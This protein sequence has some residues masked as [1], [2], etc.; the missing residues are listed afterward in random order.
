V[1]GRVEGR[2][3]VIGSG[4][5]VRATLP[6][7]SSPPA[8]AAAVLRATVAIDGVL[9]GTIE[10]A[11]SIR[12]S[13]A[14]LLRRLSALGIQRTVLLSGD[15][16]ANA[17]AI[18]AELGIVEAVGDLLP[19]DKVERVAALARDD[20]PVMMVGDGTN[21]APAL[22]RA[23][24]GIA[25]ADHG[26]GITAQSADAV[27]LVPNLERVADAIEISRRT[28][29]IARQSIVVGLGLSAVGM[30]AAALG[31]LAP[32]PGAVAQ[33][34]IDVAVILN[35]LRAARAPR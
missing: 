2:D 9:A 1:R 14:P 17:A 11:E 10:F 20:G 31:Y 13:A 24:V 32:I 26:G 6:G 8:P 12:P 22:S 16:P 21:D 30:V 15:Q 29:A 33:E 28:L 7:T 19:A 27:L 34:A 4:G 18:A 3:V 23:D 35:A 5:Y 25:L